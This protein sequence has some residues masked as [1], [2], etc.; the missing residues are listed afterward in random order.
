MYNSMH[1]TL[2]IRDVYNMYFFDMR[3]SRSSLANNLSSVVIGIN[4]R[5]CLLVALPL[6]LHLIPRFLHNDLHFIGPAPK[7]P[8]KVDNAPDTRTAAASGGQCHQQDKPHKVERNV[9]MPP[10]P[11]EYNIDRTSI[12]A[13]AVVVVPRRSN[14]NLPDAVLVDVLVRR[15]RLG[16]LVGA[17]QGRR[18]AGPGVVSPALALLVRQRGDHRVALQLP[19]R[20]Q[21]HQEHPTGQVPRVFLGAAGDEVRDGGP[22]GVCQPRVPRPLLV[23]VLVNVPDRGQR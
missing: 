17:L 22:R 12:E 14:N 9:E 7:V 4:L 1:E 13:L 15:E 6:F 19:Q 10:S 18:H 8:E 23:V 11:Q 2:Y 5:V 3:K 20:R 21:E 16:E